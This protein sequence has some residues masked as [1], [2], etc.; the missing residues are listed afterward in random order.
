MGI[1]CMTDS[2][3]IHGRSIWQPY[4]FFTHLTLDPSISTIPPFAQYYL[5]VKNVVHA[6]QALAVFVAQP[7][8]LP[9]L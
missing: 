5:R 2:S 8:L 1:D 6:I 3:S 9:G 7:S 4:S